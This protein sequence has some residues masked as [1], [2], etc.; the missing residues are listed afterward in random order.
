LRKK[1]DTKQL[2]NGA[3]NIREQIKRVS[4]ELLIRK[5]YRGFGFQQVS[6]K[7]NISRTAVHYH[8]GSKRDLVE[9]VT[10]DYTTATLRAF[11]EIWINPNLDLQTKIRNSMQLNR[12]RYRYFNAAGRTGNSW[13][14]IARMRIDRELLSRNARNA[15]TDFG[16][17]LA[18]SMRSGVEIAV[19]KGELRPDAP[20]EHITLM[21]VS[22][23]NSAGPITQDAGNFERL[24]QLYLGFGQLLDHAYGQKDS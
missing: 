17:K 21:L 23:A 3:A 12:S 1:Q 6:D 4:A 2:S 15:L 20:V 8:F 10:I 18:Q 5:G 7:L 9:E 16:K 24:E 11:E 14:L 22:I 13:S 19:H